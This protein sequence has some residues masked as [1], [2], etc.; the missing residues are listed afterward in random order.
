MYRFLLTPRWLAF[1][2]LVLLVIPAFLLLGQ[3][4]FGR[5]EER[6]A[7]SERTT[8]NLAAAPVPI[9]TLDR[10][11]AAVPESV[12]YRSVTVAGRYDQANELL[13]RRRPHTG[14]PGYNVLTPLVTADGAAV[15]VNR[16]WVAMGA[17]AD[18]PP[19]VPPA[20]SG[21]VNVT[22]RLRPAETEESTGLSDRAGLPARQVLLINTPSIA[23]RVP[24]KLFGGYVELTEQRP[25]VTPAPEPVTEPDVGGGGGL[26]LAYG[27]QWWLFIGIAVGGWFMLI[28]REARDLREQRD[29]PAGP[30]ENAAALSGRGTETDTGPA[31]H[32]GPGAGTDDTP[33]AARNPA[34]GG[35]PDPGPRP[36]ADPASRSGTDVP[37]RRS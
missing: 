3:W 4:Q 28:R 25:E 35:T 34:S 10:P 13:V 23:A 29:A 22:G 20:P 37:T 24:Y 16:G 32:G 14:R 11:G 6:S 15:L 1:H 7:A 21:E 33:G 18:T 27:V 30:P 19:T 17:T 12:K 36:A 2:A 8:A 26:N 9:T 5:F 31:G